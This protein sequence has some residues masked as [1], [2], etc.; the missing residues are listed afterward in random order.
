MTRWMHPP[1]LERPH[2][3]TRFDPVVEGLRHGLARELS[4]QIW[5]RVRADATGREGRCDMEQAERRFHE[6]AGVIA[7]RGGRLR[8]DVGRLTRVGVES[9]RRCTT[10]RSS[11]RI[12]SIAG[13]RTR[14]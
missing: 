2:K 3:G 10:V 11:L 4:L 14:A 7:A 12:P 9:R 6:L 13:A 8:P 1:E 5:D